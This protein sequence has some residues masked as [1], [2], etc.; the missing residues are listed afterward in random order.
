[1]LKVLR[2]PVSLFFFFFFLS[3]RGSKASELSGKIH[4]EFSMLLNRG[5]DEPVSREGS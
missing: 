4:M 3:L 1:M 2:I 5:L